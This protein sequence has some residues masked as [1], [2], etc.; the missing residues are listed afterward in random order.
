MHLEKT[1]LQIKGGIKENS[2]TFF[3]NFSIK[4]YDVTPLMMSSKK[5]C[6]SQRF[7]IQAG[8]EVGGRGEEMCPSPFKTENNHSHI[9]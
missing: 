4:T 2:K 7:V 3:S 9:I 8:V 1:E 6:L 5:R